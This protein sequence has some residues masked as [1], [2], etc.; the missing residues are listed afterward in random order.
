MAALEP[1]KSYRDSERE[2]FCLRKLARCYKPR[3]GTC[4]CGG[5]EKGEREIDAGAEMFVWHEKA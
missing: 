5:D 3:K 1:E 2:I 4:H